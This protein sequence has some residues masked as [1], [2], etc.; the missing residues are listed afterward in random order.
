M[1]DEII[2][3]LNDTAS[4]VPPEITDP[5]DICGRV[6]GTPNVKRYDKN[7]K[8]D[9]YWTY[10]RVVDHCQKADGPLEVKV[11]WTNMETTWERVSGKRAED[12]IMLA[13]NARE[14]ISLKKK[15]RSGQ[16]K[17]PPCQAR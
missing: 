6:Q 14:E 11:L 7:T 16:G 3:Y 1:S 12:P 2:H 5:K 10:K 8:N 15:D 9:G 4:I 17:I 13:K